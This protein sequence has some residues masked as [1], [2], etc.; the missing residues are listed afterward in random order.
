LQYLRRIFRLS[1][2]ESFGSIASSLFK[3][4]DDAKARIK[5]RLRQKQK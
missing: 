5:Q 4:P 1:D 2:Q 3:L